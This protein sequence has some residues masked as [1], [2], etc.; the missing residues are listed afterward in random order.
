MFLPLLFWPGIV[1]EFM[2]YLP[3]TLTSTIFFTIPIF[4]C[5]L[6]IPF[7]GETIRA[8]RWAAI[9]GPIRLKTTSVRPSAR[10]VGWTTS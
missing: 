3:L 5:L 4:V 9:A 6:S 8:R 7:L 2:K 10:C 1:G